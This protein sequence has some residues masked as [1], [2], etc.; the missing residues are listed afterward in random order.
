[1][2]KRILRHGNKA[3]LSL[4]Y[5]PK[6]LLTL[7]LTLLLI[8]LHEIDQ[9]QLTRVPERLLAGLMLLYPQL[10][11]QKLL[12]LLLCAA[13]VG[14][15]LKFWFILFN[16]EYLITYWCLVCTL[17]VYAKSPD[18]ILTRNAKLLIGLCFC[19]AT[20]WKLLSG[21]YLDG[22]FLHLTFLLDQR[23]EMG[24]VLFGGAEPGALAA[25]R[26]LFSLLQTRGPEETS[27]LATSL[28]LSWVSLFFSYW[29]LLSEGGIAIAFLS[30]Y[31]T[32]LSNN[33][34]WLLILFILTT[35]AVI[36]V[37]AFAA[38]LSLLGLAQCPLNLTK[39]RAIYIA[40]LLLIPIW[41]PLPQAIFYWLN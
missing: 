5:Q 8:V 21:E 26:D 31:P 7:R 20:I 19:F 28:R 41:L 16:H 14:H 3:F 34:D 27:T 6:Y 15:N 13:L 35:Y 33:R 17:A 2:I 23:L 39:R 38:I 18:Q 25:N 10:L 22:S 12:W 29:T 11:S 9:F 40:I 1:M 24:A 30:P 32:W 36:P 4:V 37:F